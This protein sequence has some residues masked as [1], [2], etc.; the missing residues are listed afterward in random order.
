MCLWKT[1]CTTLGLSVTSRQI[2][3]LLTLFCFFSYTVKKQRAVFVT[4]TASVW[5][6]LLLLTCSQV[7]KAPVLLIEIT[8]QAA[9]CNHLHTHTNTHI[10]RKH[11]SLH[12]EIY[13][14]CFIWFGERHLLVWFVV[15]NIKME[16]CSHHFMG[17]CV[18]LSPGVSLRLDSQLNVFRPVLSSSLGLSGINKYPW[19]GIQ[20]CSSACFV[21]PLLLKPVKYR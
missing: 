16:P 4:D 9:M 18:I 5:A 1:W 8:G 3:S 11:W 14:T 20:S 7:S 17:R 10:L 21:V 13:S 15:W 12:Y 19:I 2:L 6:E